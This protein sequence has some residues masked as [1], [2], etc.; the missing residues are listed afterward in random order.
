MKMLVM[1]FNMIVTRYLC[2]KTDEIVRMLHLCTQR[3]HMRDWH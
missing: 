3:L 2:V 1:R